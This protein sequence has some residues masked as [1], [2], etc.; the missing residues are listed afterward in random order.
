MSVLVLIE[1]ARIL[2]YE[3]IKVIKNDLRAIAEDKR[4]S[5]STSLKYISVILGMLKKLC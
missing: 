1:R 4:N 3:K 2:I 5:K